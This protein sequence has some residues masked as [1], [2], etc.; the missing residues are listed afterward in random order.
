MHVIP[1]HQSAVSLFNREGLVRTYA[2]KVEALREL[3]YSWISRNVGQ[4]FRRFSHVERFAFDVFGDP[5]YQT[6]DY[7]LRDEHGQALTA[8]DFW[9][10]TGGDRRIVPWVNPRYLCWNGEGPVPGTA[11]RSGGY[12]YFRRIHTYPSRRDAWHC[13]DE[14]EP[15]VRAARNAANLPTNYDDIQRGRQ[16][17]WKEH[18]KTQWKER[19]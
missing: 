8:A 10:L 5:I 19:R 4:D 7:V 13:A 1:P 14:G 15:A 6:F 9:P 2:S 16:R 12:R 17:S 18:R 11:K 3:G